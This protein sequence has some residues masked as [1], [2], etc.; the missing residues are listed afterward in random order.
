MRLLADGLYQLRGFPP[1][2]YNVYLAD[3]VLI[4]A[5]SR[6]AAR[7]ILRQVAGRAVRALALTHVH[8][9]HQG[10]SKAVCERLGIPLWCGAGDVEPMQTGQGFAGRQTNHPLNRVSRLVFAGP[11]HPV[12]RA[13]REGDAVGSFTV[14]DTP[15]FSP[16]HV[17]FWREADR[18]LLAGDVVFG[19]NPT[20]GLP[21]LHVPPR[22]DMA[23]PAR[24]GAS[25]RR[26][27]ALRPALV[28]FG[29][30]PPLRDGERF[31]D[32]V[33]RRLPAS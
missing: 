3:D 12:A 33:R 14:L 9:D 4:D 20:T 6:H 10:S 23:D 30:G 2:W 31:V 1:H 7:R 26:L 8:P 5:A 18:T 22:H 32:F 17:A 28:C 29:H 21:G 27:A 15:G 25:A 24:H 11:P 16:G 13:L 19:L